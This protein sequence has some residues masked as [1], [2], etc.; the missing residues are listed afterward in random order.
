MA[1]GFDCAARLTASM[2]R[3]AKAAGF[4]FVGR[5]LWPANEWKALTKAE[6]EAITGAGLR[7]LSVYESTADRAKGGWDAG[8]AEG[9]A[10]RRYAEEVGMPKGAIIYF[11]VDFDAKDAHMTDIAQYLAGAFSSAGEYRVGVYGSYRVIEAMHAHGVCDGYWQC[12]AWSY[13]KLSE[14]RTVYQSDWSGTAAAGAAAAQIG[15][16]VDLDECEDMDRAGIWNYES[17]EEDDMKRYNTLRE[18][19]E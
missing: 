5:Y 4:A 1:R 17:E 11:A 18:V 7:I 9:M 15:V 16:S 6:A 2:A 12:C 13:G 14:H 3:R 19:P 8:V 10:A